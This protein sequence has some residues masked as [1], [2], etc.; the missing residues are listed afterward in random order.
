M[1][2]L[3]LL[4]GGPR[5]GP[6]QTRVAEAQLPDRVAVIYLNG[7]EHFEYTGRSVD[8]DG[9]SCPVFRWIYSTKIAE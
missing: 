4:E 3:A 1:E 8:V 5:G 7:R 9:R 2:T 6:E